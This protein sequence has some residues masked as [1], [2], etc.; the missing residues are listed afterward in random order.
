MDSI[1]Y[2]SA[3]LAGKKTTFEWGTH[4]LRGL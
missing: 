1:F 3:G 2:M 4:L